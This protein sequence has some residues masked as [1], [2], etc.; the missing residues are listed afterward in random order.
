MNNLENALLHYNEC[1]SLPIYYNLTRE[2]QKFV[3]KSVDEILQKK[4]K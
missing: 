4:N 2:Q 1:I 3:I